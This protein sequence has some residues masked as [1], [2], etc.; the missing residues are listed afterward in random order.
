MQSLILSRSLT[1]L[2]GLLITTHGLYAQKTANAERAKSLKAL[3]TYKDARI[4][5]YRYT[6][7]S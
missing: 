6:S 4:A 1:I 7:F 5:S 3:D 2:I